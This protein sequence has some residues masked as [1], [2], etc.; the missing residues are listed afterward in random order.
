MLRTPP[1]SVASSP[2][3][4][5]KDQAVTPIRQLPPK[6]SASEALNFYN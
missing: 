3:L 6:K 2:S 4:D 5:S 1:E